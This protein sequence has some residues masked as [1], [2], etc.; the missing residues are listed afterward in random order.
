[1]QSYPLVLHRPHSCVATLAV[2]FAKIISYIKCIDLVHE[3]SP[4]LA[5]GTLDNINFIARHAGTTLGKGGPTG[6]KGHR[7]AW[8]T[9][10]RHHLT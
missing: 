9:S 3:E 5:A 2:Y 4:H 10:L 8:G 1:M 6:V 7:H